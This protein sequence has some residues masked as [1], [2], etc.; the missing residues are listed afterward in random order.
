MSSGKRKKS[1]L[2][3]LAPAL[4]I[5]GI[6]SEVVPLLRLEAPQPNGRL[7]FFMVEMQL[8]GPSVLIAEGIP[9]GGIIDLF[10]G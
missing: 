6:A 5:A 7:S 4:A 9:N 8:E 10:S 2:S 1:H 3:L